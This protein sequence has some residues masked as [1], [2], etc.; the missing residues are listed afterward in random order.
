[1]VDNQI[2]LKAR[3]YSKEQLTLAHDVLEE[4]RNGWVVFDAVRHHP[5]PDGGYLAKHVLVAAYRDQLNAANGNPISA[6]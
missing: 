2:W 5:M 4:V 3:Q 6:F 1:M